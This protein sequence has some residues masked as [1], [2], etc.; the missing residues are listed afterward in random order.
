MWLA[1]IYGCDVR[2]PVK[3]QCRHSEG[4]DQE[5]GS[6]FTRAKQTYPMPKDFLFSFHANKFLSPLH[7][8]MQNPRA[9]R[10]FFIL[11]TFV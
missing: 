4:A 5:A 2:W 3:R 8:R 9:L 11:Y 7:G 1:C 10:Y 6:Y